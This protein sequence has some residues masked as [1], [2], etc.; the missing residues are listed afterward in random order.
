MV[1]LDTDKCLYPYDPS[2]YVV[3]LVPINILPWKFG[4]IWQLCTRDFHRYVSSNYERECTQ[5]FQSQILHDQLSFR[6]ISS[7]VNI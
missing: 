5:I 2:C 3:I 1:L 6:K 7:I 4:G